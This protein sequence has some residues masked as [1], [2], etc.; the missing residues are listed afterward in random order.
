MTGVQTC[1]LP[2]S[3]D[4]GADPGILARAAVSGMKRVADAELEA[5]TLER[6][7]LGFREQTA[8]VREPDQPVEAAFRLRVLRESEDVEG[9]AAGL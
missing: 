4:D 1:A 5:G 8:A 2:I 7:D 9:R 3:A 6:P